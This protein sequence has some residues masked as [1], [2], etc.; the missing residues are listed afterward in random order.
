MPFQFSL[1][2][3]LLVRKNAEEREERALQKIQ[4]ELARIVR[5]VEELTAQIADT[6]LK[7]EQA[8][9][10]AI[11]AYQMHALLNHAHAAAEKRKT[12]LQHRLVL[13]E[14]RDRQMKVYQVAHRDREA[15]TDMLHKQRAAYELEEARRQQKQL[16]D[17][18][19]AR[20]HLS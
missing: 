15:L 13:E 6:N 17:I 3:V 20:R 4:V 18:F 8:M 14:E 16:D 11:P 19:I 5:Q 10:N 2:A 9:Q 7:R 12:L 1:A